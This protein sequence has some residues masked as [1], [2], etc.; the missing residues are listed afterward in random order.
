MIN[1]VSVI[2][3]MIKKYNGPNVNDAILSCRIRSTRKDEHTFKF[4]KIQDGT[5]Y[6]QP[7][8]RPVNQNAYDSLREI[9]VKHG[10]KIE[11][12]N[13]GYQICKGKDKTDVVIAD[14]QPGVLRYNYSS[15]DIKGISTPEAK[16]ALLEKIVRLAYALQISS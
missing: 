6:M 12:K 9:V 2:D 10:L 3:G 15:N 8:N 11:R 16:D 7:I 1:I 13:G 5:V 14:L 4:L